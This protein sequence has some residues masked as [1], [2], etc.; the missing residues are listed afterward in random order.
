MTY[1]ERIE[2]Y[3]T[4]KLSEG[5][6]EQVEA[7]I[8]RQEAISEYLFETEKIP[9]LE[10]LDEASSWQYYLSCFIYQVL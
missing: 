2:L 7:D 8:E 9:G 6:K 4:G 3:R 10:D 1:R 5:E